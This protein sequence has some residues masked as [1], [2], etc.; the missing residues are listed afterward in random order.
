MGGLAGSWGHIHEARRQREA[1]D[2]MLKDM[3]VRAP[4]LKPFLY[5]PGVERRLCPLHHRKDRCHRKKVP[6]K[7]P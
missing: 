2:W 5:E 3:T 6:V 1:T 4:S 7:V